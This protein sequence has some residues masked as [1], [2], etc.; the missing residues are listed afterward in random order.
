[1]V[2]PIL[3]AI[4][5]FIA[6][7]VVVVAVQ[8]EA[9]RTSRSAMMAVPAPVVFAQVNDFHNWDA[10]SPWAK[11]DPGAKKTFEGNTSGTGAIFTWSGN[12][13][14]GEGRMTVMESQPSEL[15]RLK[16]EFFKPFK[17]ANTAEFTFKPQGDQTLVTWT[18]LGKKNFIMKGMYLLMNMD[19]MIGGDFEKGLAQMKSIAEAQVSK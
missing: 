18:M 6:I 9:S 11:L 8:P 12:K 19:K 10:W 14:I 4:A 2:I 7:F 5:A 1:M 17:A 3:I 16:L 13:K 15:V